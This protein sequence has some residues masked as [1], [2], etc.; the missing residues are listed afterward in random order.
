MFSRKIFE[1][2]FATALQDELARQDMTVRD[3]AERAGI[4]VAVSAGTDTSAS[5]NVLSVQNSRVS[6]AVAEGGGEKVTQ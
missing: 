4:P 5:N 1:T 3:L 6:A 2:E